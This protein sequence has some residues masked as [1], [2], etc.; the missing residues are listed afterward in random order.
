MSPLHRHSGRTLSGSQPSLLYNSISDNAQEKHDRQS[1]TGLGSWDAS[2]AAAPYASAAQTTLTAA[3][4]KKCV[5]DIKCTATG[6]SS[7]GGTAF[8]FFATAAAGISGTAACTIRISS[9]A[10]AALDFSNED[11]VTDV[12]GFSRNIDAACAAKAVRRNSSGHRS[13][14]SR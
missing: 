5:S 14:R 3:A 7:T 11:C 12:G 9:T 13:W 10:I 1:S 2:S 4:T 8:A 6:L